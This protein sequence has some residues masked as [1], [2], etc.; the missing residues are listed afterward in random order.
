MRLL[1]SQNAFNQ[2]SETLKG[3]VEPTLWPEESF[4]SELSAYPLQHLKLKRLTEKG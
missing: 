3:P 4:P 1:K 2:N